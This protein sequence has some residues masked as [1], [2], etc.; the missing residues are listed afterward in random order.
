[1]AMSELQIALVGAGVVAVGIVWGYNHWQERKH[2]QAADRLFKGDQDDVLLK[3]APGD[4]ATDSPGPIERT[5]PVFVD[6]DAV[7]RVEPQ[8]LDDREEFTEPAVEAIAP[9]PGVPELAADLPEPLP[10]ATGDDSFAPADPLAECLVRFELTSAID[11]ATLWAARAGRFDGLAHTIQWLARNE[12]DS[13]WL[14]LQEGDGGNFTHWMA[15]LQLAD[16]RGPVAEGELAQ[17]LNG[18]S[19]LAGQW[20]AAAQT[21]NATDVLQ[22]AQALD[23]FCAS[24]DVQFG[25]HVVEASGGSFAGTKLRGVCEAA[26]L[27]LEADGA[28]HARDDNGREHYWLS[29]SGGVPFDAETIRTTNTHGITFT[30]DVPRIANGSFVFDRM[31]TTA[32]QMARG[33]GG[34]LVDAQRQPLAEPMI[35]V[36]RAK[37][38]ELQQQMQAADIA[39]GSPRALKLFS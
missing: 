12:R 9:L 31:L 4:A 18:M 26:G 32:Q 7:E 19:D 35:K 17:F 6:P 15:G 27:I 25:I 22:K 38:V 29:N 3:D 16:R 39:P 13:G 8:I 28:F 1:M 36:I 24:V 37:V 21:L 30:I 2:R 20:N 23:A 33:L 10:R 14:V 11:V 5:E 34:V